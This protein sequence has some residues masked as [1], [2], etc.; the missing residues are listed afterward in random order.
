MLAFIN[1][2]CVPG[3]GDLHANVGFSLFFGR[4]SS[5]A[6]G[7]RGVV[8][9]VHGLLSSQPVNVSKLL[10]LRIVKRDSLKF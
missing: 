5:G 7:V 3:S 2:P 10:S 6:C 8:K 9:R 1:L 4:N